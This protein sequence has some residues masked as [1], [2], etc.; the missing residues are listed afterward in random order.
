MR[1][2]S[3]CHISLVLMILPSV[4]R[5]RS[6]NSTLEIESVARQE[7]TKHQFKRGVV[8][9]GPTSRSERR[10]VSQ[11]RT[12]FVSCFTLRDLQRGDVSINELTSLK[13]NENYL[14]TIYNNTI[15]SKTQAV[16]IDLGT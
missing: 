2:Y 3:K 11:H 12:G 7:F 13:S 4:Y 14:F 15:I 9:V 8:T 5:Y 6:N 10:I 1:F 16:I